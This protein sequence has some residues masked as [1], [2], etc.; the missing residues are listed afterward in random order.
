ML[1]SKIDWGLSNP[2]TRPLR[3]RAGTEAA[4]Q[5]FAAQPRPLLLHLQ[6]Q[7]S[8]RVCQ[9]SL[10]MQSVSSHK[11]I[12]TKH[13]EALARDLSRQSVTDALHYHSPR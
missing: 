5:S 9:T 4:P 7:A 1:Y 11:T 10:L 12:H 8:D 3:S 6:L 13:Y 2:F